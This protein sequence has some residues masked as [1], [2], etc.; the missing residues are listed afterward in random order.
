M[1]IIINLSHEE[2]KSIE[3]EALWFFYIMEEANTKTLYLKSIILVN[4]I[5][6]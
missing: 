5:V 3:D 1:F 4:E 6:Q 2:C